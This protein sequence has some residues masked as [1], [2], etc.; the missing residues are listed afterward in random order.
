MESYSVLH[1]AAGV[2]IAFL[3]IRGIQ[4]GTEHYFPSSQPAAV[5]RFLFGGP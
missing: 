5:M 1:L 4:A 3:V 2:T